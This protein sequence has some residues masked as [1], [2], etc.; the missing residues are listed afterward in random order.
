MDELSV[1]VSYMSPTIIVL[2]Y[3]YAFKSDTA[4]IMKLSAPNFGAHMLIIVLSS[5]WIA[6]VI[7]MKCSF[8]VSPE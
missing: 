4:F 1:R 8:F 6:L 2:T 3:F 7:N 5:S